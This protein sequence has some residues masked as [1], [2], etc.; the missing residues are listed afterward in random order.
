MELVLSRSL[1]VVL[2]KNGGVLGKQLLFLHFDDGLD[3][4][5]LCNFSFAFPN[6]DLSLLLVDKQLLLPETLNLALVFKFP[7]AALLCIHL[8]Q[9]FVLCELLHQLGL[10]V[11]LHT[12]L[13]SSTLSLQSHLEIFRL[14][15][16]HADAITLLGLSSLLGDG[17]FFTLLIIKFITKV[18]LELLLSSALHLFL[19]KFAED[20][21]TC[22]FSGILCSL[23]LVE[24]LLLLGR[25]LSYH[26]ILVLLHFLSATLQCALFV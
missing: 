16:L 20:S 5:L 4:L 3:S 11:F 14:L 1:W 13:L 25:V 9:P 12:L 21:V 18:F 6:F 22:L 23:N 10:K 8:L 17:C 2:H 24:A 15:Q 7:H 26:F 19:L